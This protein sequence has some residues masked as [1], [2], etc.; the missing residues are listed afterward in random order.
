[1]I[2]RVDIEKLTRQYGI[3]LPYYVIE[4]F[5]KNNGGTPYRNKFRV[6][7]ETYEL[8]Y[9]LSFNEN[10]YHFI[11]KALESFQ[12]ESNGVIFPLATDSGDDYFCLNLQDD[13]IYYWDAD[14]NQYFNIARDF[15]TFIGYFK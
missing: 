6:K 5:K 14:V 2:D 4:F 1:M 7:G 9:F 13:K 11:G 15:D 3:N 8:R 10:D 12:K